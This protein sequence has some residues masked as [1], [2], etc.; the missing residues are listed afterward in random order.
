MRR[1]VSEAGMNEGKRG[2][3]GRGDAYI[4]DAMQGQNEEAMQGQNKE[5][6][7]VMMR[8]PPTQTQ[9]AQRCRDRMRKRTILPAFTDLCCGDAD[10]GR[11]RHV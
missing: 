5:V 2:V 11:K 1:S 7:L 10:K 3:G 9:W 6:N 4:A 8:I